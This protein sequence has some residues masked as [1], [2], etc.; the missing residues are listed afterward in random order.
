MHTVRPEPG[1]ATARSVAPAPN[2]WT[3]PSVHLSIPARSPT[4]FTLSARASSDD[5]GETTPFGRPVEPDVNC[6]DAGAS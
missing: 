6:T 1:N 5:H 2:C 3:N 4:S